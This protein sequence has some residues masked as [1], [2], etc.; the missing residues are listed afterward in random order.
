[1]KNLTDFC[2]TV[3][4][5]MRSCTLVQNLEEKNGHVQVIIFVICLWTAKVVII[6]EPKWLQQRVPFLHNIYV[7][8]QNLFQVICLLVLIIDELGL[9]NKGNWE[10]TYN[11]LKKFNMNLILTFNINLLPIV[12]DGADNS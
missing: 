3:E 4:T 1:M 11:R 2:K 6:C 5:D 12:N 8:V 10:S 9:E 7:T